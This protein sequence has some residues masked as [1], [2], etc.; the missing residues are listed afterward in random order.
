[1]LPEQLRTFLV[2][3]LFNLCGLTLLHFLELYTFYLTII[4]IDW[5]CPVQLLTLLMLFC[6]KSFSDIGILFWIFLKLRYK[7][8][9]TGGR[10][11][12]RA[13]ILVFIMILFYEYKTFK[14]TEKYSVCF[15][16]SAEVQV[17]LGDSGQLSQRIHTTFYMY[18]FRKINFGSNYLTFL[19][20][21]VSV[22]FGRASNV[23]PWHM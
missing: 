7:W 2:E 9:N 23:M 1:M 13:A 11:D 15:T 22:Q 17:Q 19:L 3:S 21:K 16:R 5:I 10:V 20:F 14:N 4:D 6:A 12:G 8:R 18:G